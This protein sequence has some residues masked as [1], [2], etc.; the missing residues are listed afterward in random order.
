MDTNKVTIITENN[1][2]SLDVMTK[3]ETAEKI[4]DAALSL[5]KSKRECDDSC[6]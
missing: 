4:L 3:K 6:N 2:D 1:A 5:L